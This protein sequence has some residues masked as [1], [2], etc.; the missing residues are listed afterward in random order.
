M[1]PTFRKIKAPSINDVDSI[2]DNSWILSPKNNKEFFQGQKSLKNIDFKKK[3]KG[4][5]YLITNN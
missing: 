1:N 2:F 4:S 5:N 3:I